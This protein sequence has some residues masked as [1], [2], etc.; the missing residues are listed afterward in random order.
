MIYFLPFYLHADDYNKQF[1]NGIDT[2]YWASR[3]DDTLYTNEEVLT[4]IAIQPN[5]PKNSRLYDN[6]PHP[7]NPETVIGW[8]LAIGSHVELTVHNILG[9]K[10]STLVS[11]RM[12]PGTHSYRF[13]G[14]N[15]AS[16]VYY[17]Q[18]VAGD[19]RNLKK[20]ILIK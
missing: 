8:Q 12:E 2:V 13:N 11:K 18:L 16:G 1:N 9:E 20:M 10:V 17:N 7:F 4:G 15:L 19:Y 3:I 6:Y 14:K 5:I